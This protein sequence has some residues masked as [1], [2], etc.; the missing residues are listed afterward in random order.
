MNLF[1]I[2]DLQHLSGI[3]AHTIRMWEQR[4]QALRPNRSVG[5]T[6][7]YDD[8]QLRRLLNIVSLLEFDYKVSELCSL[9][10]IQIFHLIEGQ[11]KSP[12]PADEAGE[13]L[14]T[15][16][17]AAG[18]SFDEYYFEKIF[19]NSIL[20][21]GL[22]QTYSKVLFPMLERIGF[23]WTANK[24]SSA[25]EHFISNLVKQKLHSA[26]DALPPAKANKDIWLL[27]LPEN[28]FHEIGLLF[29]HY[30]IKLSGN[31]SIYLGANTPLDAIVSA[32]E[33][34]N[35]KHILIFL[36]HNS[37]LEQTQNYINK[38]KGNTNKVVVHLAG[39][40]RL[41][42]ALKLN[43]GINRIQTIKELEKQLV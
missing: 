22:S 37:G 20:R 31:Q 11:L 5:N 28:E 40:D 3:K 4:Y 15:Q 26:I 14:A 8:S 24:I 36:V 13:Y 27:F 21:L 10:D 33:A 41:L 7:Y 42:S 12:M 18:M 32:T 43:K 19:S 23:M 1:S 38:L 9:P 29:S 6:R 39:N 25:H 30:L 17:I 2:S 16:L 34:L 35:P